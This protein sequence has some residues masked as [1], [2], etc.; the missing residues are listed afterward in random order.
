MT[1]RGD[2]EGLTTSPV[3]CRLGH[4][5]SHSCVRNRLLLVAGFSSASGLKGDDVQYWHPL[6][7]VERDVPSLG[8]VPVPERAKGQGW[9]DAFELNLSHLRRPEG[10][11]TCGAEDQAPPD[12]EAT[13]V[14]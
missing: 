6:E 7:F 3:H 13:L 1:W 2:L 12:D 4:A 11:G 14:Q 8:R 5:R 9:L 10:T